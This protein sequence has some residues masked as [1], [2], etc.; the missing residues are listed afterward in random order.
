M[1]RGYCV[2]GGAAIAMACDL[3]IASDDAK[4]GIPIARTLGN[5]LSM[6][7]LDRLTALLCAVR[8]KRPEELQ[9][10]VVGHARRRPLLGFDKRI[11]PIVR[12]D[13]A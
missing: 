11:F 10:T 3:R 5:T 6:G 12:R 4:F 13:W 8:R 7:N 1:I 9:Q 2:G